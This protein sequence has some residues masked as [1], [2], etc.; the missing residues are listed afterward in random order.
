MRGTDVMRYL[1]WCLPILVVLS[2][3]ERIMQDMYDQ[4]RDKTYSANPM[5]PDN[6]SSR[7]PPV[8]TVP[9][10]EGSLAGN[11]SGRKGSDF[12]QR[13]RADVAATDQPY[14]VDM[15]LLKRGQERYSIY[16]LP[17]HS[18]VGDGDGRV[19]R[20]GFP[21]PPTY[22]SDRLRQVPDRYIFDVITHGYGVMASYAD[23]V[24]PADR[25]AIVAYIRALQLSQNASL[26]QMP[27]AMRKEAL[28]ALS[29][30]HTP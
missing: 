7:I 15:P 17:C 24:T 9:Y 19:V 18:P 11:T 12:T 22:H 29:G 28:S 13:K 23:R 4:P 5:F 6:A 2:G 1:K 26:S 25:W 8:G 30:E 16:C 27:E 21:A 3:C 10:A 14:E 20:R